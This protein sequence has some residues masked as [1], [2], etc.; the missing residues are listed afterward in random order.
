ME[1]QKGILVPQHK[2]MAMGV[3]IT[4]QTQATAKEPKAQPKQ[5]GL[6]HTKKK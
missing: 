5:G 3:P 6:S 1:E 2:R 4:G